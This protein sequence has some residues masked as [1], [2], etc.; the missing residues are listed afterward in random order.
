MKIAVSHPFGNPNVYQATLAFHDSASLSKYHTCLFAPLGS[1]H[2]SFPALRNAPIEIHPGREVLRLILNNLP[3]SSLN[4]RRQSCV[5]WVARGFDLAVAKCLNRGIDAVYCYEDSAFNT[6]QAAEHC[7]VR[8]FYELPIGYHDEAKAIANEELLRNEGLEDFLS[9][10]HEPREKVDRKRCEVL[11]ADH[12][13]CPSTYCYSTLMKHVDVRVKVSVLPYGCD[14]SNSP[15]VWS[16]DDLLGPL[17]LL[18]VGRLDPRKGL[19][20]LF[21]ALEKFSPGCFFLTLAGRWVPGYREWLLKR[22]RVEFTDLGQVDGNQKLDL[23]RRSHLLVFPSL[24]EGFGLVLLEAMACGVPILASERTGAPDIIRDRREGFLVRAAQSDDIAV[25]L[26]HALDARKELAEM[27][28]NARRKAMTMSWS[29]YRSRLVGLVEN[30]V[31]G[32]Q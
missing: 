14:C 20:Y 10:L 19:H 21:Q 5:D 31:M 28:I 13:V 11:S 7:A 4:G 18:F 23:M 30:D 6:F 17:K 12:I 24:F 1:R 26:G 27:G 32:T 9:C 25:V 8:K 22:Y 15:R 3:I 2:R 29:A 16:A